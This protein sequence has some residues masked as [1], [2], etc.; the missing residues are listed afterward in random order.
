[1][2]NLST[3]RARIGGPQSAS[4][5][6]VDLGAVRHNMQALRKL[7][8]PTCGIW[9]VVK[10]NGYGHGAVPVAKAALEGG[11]A[12]L[13]VASWLEA[14][15]L[16]R[17]GI[18]SPI[19]LLSAGDPRLATQV[20]KHE[21]TQTVCTREM[22]AALSRSARRLGKTADA[23]LKIDTGLGR[24]GVLPEAAGE[25]AE[26]LLTQE[27]VWLGGVFS[28]LATAEAEETGY[29]QQQFARFGRAISE[30]VAAG[31]DPGIRHLANS[32]AALRFPEMRLDRVRAGLLVYGIRPD[33][34]GLAEI[35]LRPALTWKARLAFV[36]EQPAGS[37]ISYGGTHITGD[38]CRTAV[39]PLGYA[40]GYPRHASN[41]AHVLV[42]GEICPVIGRVCM[43]H[44]IVEVT[45]AG[46]V[47]PGEEAVLIGSQGDR[48]ISANELAQWADTC[49]HEVTTVIGRR[50]ARVYVDHPIS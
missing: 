47:G 23:H 38:R 4:W 19:L 43:D 5:V 2:Q 46:E 39:L 40:D 36:Q 20:V 3:S 13:A 45:A 14:R 10:A 28:H 26:F 41:R 18:S 27:G 32:A 9:A 17:A 34:P 22:V 8:G 31:A 50:V 24:L 11:A 12:G 49:A 21:I 6:E 15:E 25:F 48:C 1:M 7:I 37:A 42:R 16:R 29:A 35:D 30:V 44:V 33:V